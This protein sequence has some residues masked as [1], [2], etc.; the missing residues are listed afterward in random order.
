MT[1]THLALRRR[2]VAAVSVVL[3]VFTAVLSLRVGAAPV[4]W[5]QFVHALFH[6]TGTQQDMIVRDLR[7]PRVLVAMEVGIGFA[8]AGTL[9]Q[10]LTRNPLA[11]PGIFGINAGAALSVVIGIS[12]FGAVRPA[13][14][15]WFAFPGALAASTTAFVISIAARGRPTPVTLTLA[16]VITATLC[17]AVTGII[18]FLNPAV[19]E[20]F[21]FWVIGNVGGRG[22]KVVVATAPVVVLGLAVALT[23][24]R[25]LNALSLGED[26]ARTLGQ[27][28]GVTKAAAIVA[29][30]L[31]AGA[32][33]AAA[34]PIAFVGLAVPNALRT[35]IGDDYRWLL[36]LS[37][38]T[39][40]TFVL[41][42]DVIGRV[43]DRPTEFQTGLVISAI[44]APLFLYLVSRRRIR[45]L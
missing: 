35:I 45:T 6:Y 4:G 15:V 20:G 22:I 18:T 39:G 19:A 34:G 37:A 21:Q 17:S 2:L 23:L 32:S 41:G 31:L 30:I 29:V 7:G 3:L 36:P 8:V 1:T 14:Y 26:V 11:D 33:V 16:G 28:V 38:L 44:G 42:T 13:E 5:H 25:S 40:A 43:I 10:G 12:V 9:V 27:R 24:G